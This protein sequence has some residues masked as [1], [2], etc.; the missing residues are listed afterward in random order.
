MVVFV[1]ELWETTVL[2]WNI[3][4]TSVFIGIKCLKPQ[5]IPDRIGSIKK[6]SMKHKCSAYISFF[7]MIGDSPG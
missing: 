3:V 1:Y 4:E 7:F 5:P 6:R 2:G